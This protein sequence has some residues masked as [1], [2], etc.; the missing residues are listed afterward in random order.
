MIPLV[1]V[2]CVVAALGAGV[3]ALGIALARMQD[4]GRHVFGGGRRPLR[5]L[6][7][8]ATVEMWLRWWDWAPV[9]GHWYRQYRR[10]S[11]KAFAEEMAARDFGATAR[12]AEDN[13]PVHDV[14]S[15]GWDQIR[16]GMAKPSPG[17][18]VTEAEVIAEW[19]LARGRLRARYGDGEHGHVG[20]PGDEWPAEWPDAPVR[21]SAGRPGAVPMSDSPAVV[22]GV[23]W[24]V[25]EGYQPRR[26]NGQYLG[27]QPRRTPRPGPFTAVDMPA[28]AP[29][30]GPGHPEDDVDPA[31][32]V[33]GFARSLAYGVAS[34]QLDVAEA[35]RLAEAMRP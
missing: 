11:R 31:P 35:E 29:E 18:I 16:A 3:A 9:R 26:V 19:E 14:L 34:C 32:P 17:G 23:G 27:T 2:G 12:P 10:D 25:P 5:P 4:K 15:A 1:I 24:R 8:L 22:P 13:P 7:L 6:A 28:C 33:L 21:R 30:P 20:G